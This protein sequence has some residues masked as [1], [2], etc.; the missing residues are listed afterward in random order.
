MHTATFFD[1]DGSVHELPFKCGTTIWSHMCKAAHK[2]IRR[3][4]Y[5]T[6][7]LFMVDYDLVEP[8]LQYA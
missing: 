2:A 1:W 3:K 4:G 7:R 8:F 6:I 5:T